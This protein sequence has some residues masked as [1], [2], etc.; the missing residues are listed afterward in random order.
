MARYIDFNTRMRAL[1]TSDFAKDFFKL[2]N[3]SVFGKCQENL[4]N[5]MTVE[6]I[7]DESIA[8]KRVCKPSMKRSYII[9]EDLVV[10]ENQ[11]TSLELN[12]PVYTGATV[13]DLSKL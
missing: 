1:A 4:R 6:I 9:R 7:T 10:V 2:M 12:R 8:K 11:I 3:N 5:R 13:L